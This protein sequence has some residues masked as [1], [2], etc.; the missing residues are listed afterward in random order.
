MT[1]QYHQLLKHI[2]DWAHELGFNAVGVAPA[3]LEQEEERFERWLR[4]NYHGDMAWLEERK[5]MRLSP[6][7][8]HPNTTRIISVRM[9]Y[10]PENTEQIKV[11]K[12]PEK[13]YV[14]RYALGRDYHKLMRKRLANLAERIEAFCTEHKMAE[15]ISQRPFVDSA[16]VLE[17][18]LAA[19][20]GLGWVGKHTLLIHK[21]AGSWFF[22]GEI[23]TNV[24]LPINTQK[25]ENQCGDCQACLQVC[26]TDAFPQPYVLDARRCISYLTIENKGPIPEEFREVMGNRVFGCDDCQAICPWNKY[27]HHSKESDFQPRHQLQNAELLSLFKWTEQAFL[28]RTAGSPIRRIGYVNWLRNLAVGLGNAPSSDA[29]IHALEARLTD[30]RGHWMEEQLQWAIARQQQPPKTR[31]RK[32]KVHE[33]KN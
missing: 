12:S 24:P 13:A 26:P 22:L 30:F 28:D 3:T 25:H 8:L 15:A 32:L 29:I 21:E 14:S 1:D 19:Q 20:A 31:K 27:A 33:R 18:P 2:E 5:A 6:E 7:Q 17:R 23:Y 16:P 4:S 11:L 10:L 9:N